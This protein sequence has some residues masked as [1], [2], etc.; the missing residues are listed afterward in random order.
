LTT[1]LIAVPFQFQVHPPKDDHHHFRNRHGYLSINCM[2]VVGATGKFHYCN[3]SSPGSQ[4]DSS[5]FAASDLYVK[6]HYEGWF[7]FPRSILAGDSAY[8]TTWPFLATPHPD[9]TARNNPRQRAYNLAFCRSRVF[10]EQGIGRLKKR[11]PILTGDG[12]RFPD[13][14]K[15]AKTIQV[16]VAISNFI[17]IKQ[18]SDVEES[19]GDDDD[20]AAAAA[21][22][23]DDDDN[24][25]SS[26]SD[27]EAVYV[28]RYANGRPRIVP[29]CEKITHQYF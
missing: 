20:A 26:D 8:K 23:A 18:Q 17:L 21:A 19:F 1:Y 5:I 7:P 11:F 28:T 25:P 27:N 15:C 13:M 12:I 24:V 29:T 16:C 10:I 22:D 14:E 6:L 4:H 9:A 2:L 3:S